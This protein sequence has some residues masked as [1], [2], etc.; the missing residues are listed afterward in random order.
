MSSQLTLTARARRAARL[1]AVLALLCVSGLQVLE[2][3]HTHGLSD[4]QAECLLCKS[5][6]PAAVSAVPALALFL[7]LVACFTAA[8]RAAQVAPRYLPLQARG[9]PHY[10]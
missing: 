2:A 8:P 10:F 5:S 7:L 6:V 4:A 3:S 9:P 1:V